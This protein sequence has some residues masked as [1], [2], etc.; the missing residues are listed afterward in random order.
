MPFGL[1]NPPAQFMDMMNALLG[2]YFDKFVLVFLYDILISSANM[3]KHFAHLY[4][5]LEIL[6]KERLY[7]KASGEV[8]KT[9]IEFL[10]QQTCSEGMTPI[11]VS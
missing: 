2:E 10:S 9:S 4:Q 7:A 6:R 3:P 5:V 8:A 11:E 1:N